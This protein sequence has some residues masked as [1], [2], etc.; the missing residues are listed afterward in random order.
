MPYAAGQDPSW[1]PYV[2]VVST[3]VVAVFAVLQVGREWWQSRQRKRIA[4]ARISAA[5]FRLRKL[6]SAL[7]FRAMRED[8]RMPSLEEEV[9]EAY[10]EWAYRLAESEARPFHATAGDRVS[11]MDIIESR[12]A[13][14]LEEAGQA[15]RSRSAAIRDAYL[16]FI[17][18]KDRLVS[19]ASS[20]R[21]PE[22]ISVARAADADLMECV[23]LLEKIVEAELQLPR[24]TALRDRAG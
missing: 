6:M 22:L 23:G 13:S 20:A 4:H 2:N 24:G 11:A 16:V 12:W 9:V 15:S 21:T 19:I 5:A 18:T 10:W 8:A 3:A 1:A 7:T 17:R 14:L